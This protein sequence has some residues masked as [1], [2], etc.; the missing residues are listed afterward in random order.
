MSSTHDNNTGN[1]NGNEN[2]NVNS[3]VSATVTVI[4]DEILERADSISIN[5]SKSS[6]SS[7]SSSV[8]VSETTKDSASGSGTDSSEMSDASSVDVN[9]CDCLSASQTKDLTFK[10]YNMK[11][12]K[13]T[14]TFY[15]K[16]AIDKVMSYMYN[17]INKVKAINRDNTIPFTVVRTSHKYDPK[18]YGY[19]QMGF[20]FYKYDFKGHI[21][22]I[23]YSQESK[24]VGTQ[25]TAEKYFSLTV[26]TS[27]CD[28]F[29]K[30]YKCAVNFNEDMEVDE[31]QLHI[32]IMNKYGDWIRYNKIPSRTLKTVYF[33][34]K[35]KYK[36][37]DDLKSFLTQEK[38]YQEFGIPFKK[39]YLITGIPGSG[40]TSMIK[41]LCKEI[42]YNLCIFSINHDVDNTTAIIAFRDMPPKSI[43]LIEDIDCL[44]EKRTGTEE[45]KHF[46]FSNLINLLDGVLSKQGLITF[47]TTN[48]P[49]SM[50]HALLRQGRVDLIIH[51][52]YPRRVDIKNLF[53]DI[54]KK[55]YTT[56]DEIDTEFDSFYSFI[57][58]KKITMAAIVGFLFRFRKDWKD[59]ID[60]LLDGDRFI[61]EVTKN[62]EESKLYS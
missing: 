25:D 36:V 8:S 3:D 23:E 42:G 26:T 56:L 50:D 28:M 13:Y 39:N 24:V 21:F 53:R 11:D 45:N 31:S 5:S 20:G 58:T 55:S 52:N 7:S 37:R 59:N 17:T 14:Y 33:D 29:D 46:T 47:I 9:E 1:E 27:S 18:D 15:S 38:E 51:M 60:D 62:I 4:M 34:E 6:T 41:A 35:I 30:F 49:E 22:D 12:G 2:G 44:F 43:L 16:H 61:K 54:M 40:K 19:S 48:H 10:P 32:Y 57:Q